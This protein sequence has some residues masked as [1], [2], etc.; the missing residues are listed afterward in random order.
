[1]RHH[2]ESVLYLAEEQQHMSEPTAD[3]APFSVRDHS[4]GRD[5]NHGRMHAALDNSPPPS[6][7]EFSTAP[8]AVK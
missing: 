6:Q 2:S 7:P 1:M 3:A 4:A 8:N 5:P